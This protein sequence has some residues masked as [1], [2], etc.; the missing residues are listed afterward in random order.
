MPLMKTT[1][2]PPSPF[3][4]GDPR[5]APQPVPK[6][7]PK[8]FHIMTKPG[9]SICNLDCTYCFYLEKERLY[10]DVKNFRMSDEVLENYIRQYIAQQNTPEITFAWQGGEP[11]LLG[12]PFFEKAVHLQQKYCPPGQRIANAFQ[13]NGTLLDDKWCKFFHDHH[14]LIGLSID[15]PREMHDRYRVN[16]GGHPTFDAVVRGLKLM[17]NHKV[18]FNTLTVVNKENSQHP[19]EVYEFLKSM[20]VEFMQFIPLVERIGAEPK[21]LAEPPLLKILTPYAQVTPWSVEPLAFGQ[22]LSA[23]F[24]QWVRHDVGRTFVQMFDVQLGIEMGLGSALCVFSETCGKAMA[25]EFNGDL[26]SCDHFVYPQYKLGNIKDKTIEEMVNSAQQ[27]EFGTAKRDTLPRY[28]QVCPVKEHCWGECPKHRFGLT[29]DGEP[30][31]NYLCA[32]YKQFFTHIK[33][34]LA[35]MSDLLR[36]QRPASDIMRL[37]AVQEGRA[38]AAMPAP[39]RVFGATP[40]RNEPCPCGSGKKY[41]KCCGG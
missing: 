39:T 20:G 10:P 26:Y 27:T 37:I 9:G 34:Y 25:M 5:N 14:F 38:P 32:G 36:R 29:P 17:Q 8:T 2:T 1:L 11:T 13:T 31:L 4:I 24:D 33:P 12:L 18:E 40:G 30:G 23:I 41:K 35:T 3:P 21:T 6:P 28:C 22:F 15:G 19:L 7:T 16:K